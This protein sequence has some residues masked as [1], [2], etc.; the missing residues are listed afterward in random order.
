[1]PIV[2]YFQYNA[3]F[4]IFHKCKKSKVL[5]NPAFSVKCKS[6][7]IENTLTFINNYLLLFNIIKNTI[8][9]SD[10]TGMTDILTVTATW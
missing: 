8:L 10:Y 5:P 4:S 3:C 1:M 9:L 2:Q 7:F 6:L